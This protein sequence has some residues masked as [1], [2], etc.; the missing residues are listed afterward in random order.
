M[1]SEGNI[2]HLAFFEALA[3]ADESQPSWH[4]ISAG[5]VT[6]RLVDDW[7]AAPRGSVMSE[8]WG[9]TA[10]REAIAEIEDNTPLRRILTSIVDAVVSA[11]GGEVL[12]SRRVSWRMASRSSTTRSG[13]S[14]PTSIK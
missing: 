1:Y 11:P 7:L 10:V 13:R 3:K 4:S 8:S 2:R 6:M 9:V 12:P 14:P 5:L